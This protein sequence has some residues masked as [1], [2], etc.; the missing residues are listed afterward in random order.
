L[1][2]GAG[3]LRPLTRSSTGTL[4]AALLLAGC[5]GLGPAPDR[6]APVTGE[7]AVAQ[8]L[9]QLPLVRD[10]ELTAY[11]QALGARLAQQSPR[12]DVEYQ[13][14]VVDWPE[15]NAFAGPGGFVFVTRGLL[16]F[17]NSEDE[18]ANVI[19]HEIGHIAGRHAAERQSRAAGIDLANRML[20]SAIAGVAGGG[21]GAGAAAQAGQVAGMGLNAAYNR[22]QERESDEIGQQ[23]AAQAGWDPLGMTRFLG[24]LEQ[25]EGLQKADSQ[26][27]T[28]LASH[29]TLGERVDSTAG[30]A[31][32][33][34]RGAARP[35]TPKQ[36]D[37]YRRIDRIRVGPDPAL[38]IFQ[39]QRFLH[40]D[41]DF[42]IDFPKGWR[43]ANQ[44][45]A[46]VGM[47]PGRDALLGVEFQAGSSDPAVAAAEF[48][49]LARLEIKDLASGSIGGSPAARA[50][51]VAGSP[52]GPLSLE[53]A[54]IARP[55]GTLRVIALA[56]AAR[57]AKYQA[58]FAA[59]TD[60]VA[61]LAR[62]DRREV[63][64]YELRFTK[65][66]GGESMREFSRRTQNRWPADITAIANGLKPG[67]RLE[68]DRPMKYIVE[69]PY[70]GR[71]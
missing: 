71:R 30:R 1:A 52:A 59:A 7:A 48:A 53:L 69:V 31:T 42:R 24:T 18:L 67:D 16:A 43:L 17:T 21:V 2:A 23:V 61:P 26:R 33:L 38:G 41:L 11:V 62:D 44:P 60:S 15:P 65:G 12:Q 19:G 66:F 22:D 32:T 5:A 28:Y 25:I 58:E 13:F 51:A 45:A 47:A 29:P 63:V 37:Y 49:K 9:P 68:A 54:W 4:A 40:A 57:A 10:P 6:E 46:V 39:G 27:P 3:D 20:G 14:F 35:V 55:G 8:A 34:G 56:P 70:K 50:R 64:G 36:R